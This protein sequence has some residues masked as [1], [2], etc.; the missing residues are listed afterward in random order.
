LAYYALEESRFGPNWKPPKVSG[1]KN[2]STS[3]QK[4]LIPLWLKM[5]GLRS[6]K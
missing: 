4:Q 1:D 5:T 2:G 3:Q 6:Q